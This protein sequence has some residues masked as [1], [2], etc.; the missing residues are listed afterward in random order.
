MGLASEWLAFQFLRR[1]H[2]EVVGETCWISG[3]R[4]RFFG[5][6]EGDD[7]AGY[8]FCV[9]TPQ[10]EWLYEV[11]SSLEDTGEFELTPNEMR[12]AASVSRRGRRR[13][14][15]LYVPFVFSP[16]RWFVLEL[17]N[18]MGDGTRNRFKQVGR[19]SVRLQLRAF[20][21]QEDNVLRTCLESRQRVAATVPVR[22]RAEAIH[23]GRHQDRLPDQRRS[24]LD[25]HGGGLR[26]NDRAEGQAREAGLRRAR[27][28]CSTRTAGTGACR[29]SCGHTPTC[30]ALRQRVGGSARPRHRRVHGQG[31]RGR[32]PWSACG[33][34]RNR[35][36]LRLPGR[37]GELRSL[38]RVPIGGPRWVVRSGDSHIGFGMEIASPPRYFRCAETRDSRAQWTH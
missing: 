30:A 5:G 15:I 38:C 6:D 10:A 1:R 4:S 18:P 13:Y 22:R 21:R 36:K 11:K 8:D 26:I 23:T 29:R 32:V 3:N 28:G 33:V 34:V 27:V 16:D 7:S 37:T 9:K 35:R 20:N 25:P 2:G 17:P 19:G 31:A 12:I 14:R 24:A